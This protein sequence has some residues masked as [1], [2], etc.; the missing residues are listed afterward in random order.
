[1]RESSSG[2]IA[3]S[4]S[5]HGGSSPSSLSKEPIAV[6]VKRGGK[7]VHVYTLQELP[8][9]RRRSTKLVK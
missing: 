2:K 5:A 9:K 8:E 4:E 3:D 6:I 7:L 1:M